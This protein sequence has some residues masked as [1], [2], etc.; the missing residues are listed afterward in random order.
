MPLFLA[1]GFWPPLAAAIAGGVSGTTIMAF[2]LVPA[3]YAFL[4]RRGL[5][6]PESRAEGQ[7]TPAVVPAAAA[8]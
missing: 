4:V 1:G 6:K 2:F 3:A 5:L 8:A 7:P